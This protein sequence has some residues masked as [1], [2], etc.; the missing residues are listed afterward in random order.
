MA[1]TERKT[2]RTRKNVIENTDEAAKKKAVSEKMFSESDV[3]A[4]IAKAVADALAKAQQTPQPAQ[5][6]TDDSVTVMFIAEVSP[7]NMLVIPGYG[8]LRPTSTLDIPKNEFK[9]KFMMPLV[10]KLIDK[11][12]LIVLNGLTEDER[13]RFNCNYKEGEVMDEQMFDHVLDLDEDKL[14]SAFSL[15]CDEHK[16]FV[17]RKIITAYEKQQGALS[18]EKMQAINNLTKDIVQ[19]GLL[20]PVIGDYGSKLA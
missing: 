6:S 12:H 10:R 7:E 2:T 20:K 13:K 19:G 9:G 11:R 3:Q 4:M 8:S 14:V 5:A 15:L 18:I 1:E 16:K 17:C